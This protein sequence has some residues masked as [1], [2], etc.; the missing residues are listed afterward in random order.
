MN[1]EA[2]IVS[3]YWANRVKEF[4]G[5]NTGLFWWDAGPDIFAYRNQR[6]SGDPTSDWVDYTLRKYFAGKL[7][8]ARCLS[9]GCGGGRLERQLAKLETFEHCDAYDVSDGAIQQ[10]KEAAQAKGLHHISYFVT[11]INAISLPEGV[12]DAVWIAMAMHH[13]QDLEHVCEQIKKSLKPDGLLILEEYVGPNRFQ[14]SARQKEVT[15]LCL[16]LLPSRY[17]KKAIQA[18]QRELHAPTQKGLKWFFRRL[19]DKLQDGS[20][21][22]AVQRRLNAYQARRKGQT[23]EKHIVNFPTVRDVIAA[24]PSESIRSEEILQV[25]GRYFDIIENKGW[26]GNILQFLLADIAGNFSEQDPHARNFLQ[27]LIRIEE[28]Y[29]ASGEFQSD[30]A[31]VVA[32]PLKG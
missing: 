17:R 20:L 32:R 23:V 16:A 19:I 4:S 18:M 27:M 14:F 21:R 28:A 29:L 11:D 25:V 30:F 31:Y 8:L 6:I 7:P 10:A 3:E 13:F 1:N 5:K 26:G 2:E 24:D 12:Y 9:L 15:N 22:R